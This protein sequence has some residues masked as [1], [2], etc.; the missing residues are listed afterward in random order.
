MIYTKAHETNEVTQLELDNRNLAR[1]LAHEAIVLLK[2]DGTLPLSIGKVALYGSGVT[3]TIS[4]GTGSGEVRSRYYVNVYDGFK[5]RGFEI[6]SQKWLDDY[7]KE[8]QDGLDKYPK[9]LVKKLFK[10]RCFDDLQAIFGS[11]YQHPFGREITLDDVKESDT[12]I[13]C[14]VLTRQVGEGKDKTI[15][16]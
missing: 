3:K 9:Y 6:S 16:W 7:E 10:S 4:G 2:N 11:S 15:A 1:K 5:N 13:C 12:D 8:F 14:Y